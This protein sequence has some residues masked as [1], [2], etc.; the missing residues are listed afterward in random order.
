MDFTTNSLEHIMKQIPKGQPS[1]DYIPPRNKECLQ[2]SYFSGSPCFYCVR[3]LHPK[4]M[5]RMEK[6]GK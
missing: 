3:E 4:S 1:V 2:C 5:K 6:A